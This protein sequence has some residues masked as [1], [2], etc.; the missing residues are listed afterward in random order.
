[1]VSG[2]MNV[3]IKLTS[4]TFNIMKHVNILQLLFY[5]C[6]FKIGLCQ[7]AE[8]N[9]TALV[10]IEFNSFYLKASKDWQKIRLQGFDSYVGG[11]TNGKDT[12]SFDFGKYSSDLT[13][14]SDNQLY[15]NDTING[16]YGIVT[17]PKIKGK[18]TLGVYF[19]NIDGRSFNLYTLNSN[20]EDTII[21]IFQSIT[22]KTSNPAINSKSLRFEPRKF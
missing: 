13:E 1:V 22:F 9:D 10:I 17:K 8:K 21:D 3:T 5:I 4:L 18:G 12:L 7:T 2:G 14:D 19:E 15:A 16:K 11:I 20:N 6:L